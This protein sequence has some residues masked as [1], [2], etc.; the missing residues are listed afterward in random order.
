[1]DIDVGPQINGKP[2]GTAPTAAPAPFLGSSWTGT[3]TPSAIRRPEITTI[4]PPPIRKAFRSVPNTESIPSP[5]RQAPTKISPTVAAA[6]AATCCRLTSGRVAVAD[7]NVGT[8]ATGLRM[9]SRAPRKPNMSVLN[10]DI[11]AQ[12]CQGRTCDVEATSPTSG[13]PQDADALNDMRT[14]W[15]P[16]QKGRT[17]R[18][19]N[20]KAIGECRQFRLLNLRRRYD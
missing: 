2:I 13:R 3:P 18:D 19:D 11:M 7:T 5:K 12:H 10:D 14:R 9:A 17:I 16:G 6:V 8:A 1:M 15:L 20:G 4:S